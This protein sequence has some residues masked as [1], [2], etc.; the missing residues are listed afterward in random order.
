MTPE[1]V[2]VIAD[3][4]KREGGLV[5]TPDKAYLV[6]GRVK[7]LLHARAMEPAELISAL[8]RGDSALAA[9]VVDALTNNETSF[10]RD[11]APFNLFRD[12]VLPALA[13]RRGEGV[14]R[15]WSAACATGQEPYSLAMLIDR[16]VHARANLAFD[17]LGTD[18]SE[19]CLKAA[20]EGRYS[21]FEVQ[22]GVS[23]L[24]RTQYFEPDGKGWRIRPALR[25]KVRW[26][27]FNLL[28]DPGDL[29]RADVV[30]CRNVLIYFDQDTRRRVLEK[31]AGVMAPDGYLF[32]GASETVFGLRDVFTAVAA[33]PGVY[34]PL[35][36]GPA[37]AS[38]PS[39]STAT[40]R[41][42]RPHP[43]AAR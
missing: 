1:Q 19:T 34:Q 11:K 8:K 24:E 3:L 41:D 28:H 10:F 4:A 20:R 16:S 22:R 13:R 36:R 37:K 42:Y 33:A 18:M 23:A 26:R 14:I 7:P 39:G 40:A 29:G 25:D 15:I 5:F 30:F 9:A 32:L 6:E 31:I 38:P 27:Q 2:A 35:P 43:A 17:I 21:E 12:H